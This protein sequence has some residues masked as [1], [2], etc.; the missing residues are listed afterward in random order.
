MLVDGGAVVA[1]RA[2]VAGCLLLVLA[3]TGCGSEGTQD[4]AAGSASP[5]SSP[6]SASP[7]SSAPSPSGLDARSPAD[8]VDDPSA[9]LVDVAVSPTDPQ[10]RAAVWW[11]CPTKDCAS[12]HVAV[13]VSTDGFATRVVADRVWR[14]VPAVTVDERGNTVVESFGQRVDLTLVRPDGSVVDVRRS[15]DE[16][17]VGAGE[18]VAGAEFAVAARPSGPPT[19]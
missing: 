8:V 5:A 12:R 19:R 15:P 4:P 7:A 1:G 9:R 11:T 3:V 13:A 18:I 6:T 10:V 16:A 17:T 14:S 2:R